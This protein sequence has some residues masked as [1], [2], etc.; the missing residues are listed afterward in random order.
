MVDVPENHVV[1]RE[2]D[3]GDSFYLMLEGHVEVLRTELNQEYVMAVL[4]PGE[5]FG[6]MALL[7]EA[8]R[9]ATIRS[10]DDCRLLQIKSEDFARLMRRYPP[11]LV[12]MNTLMGQRVSLLDVSSDEMTD[13]L[14]EHKLRFERR[15]E[16]DPRRSSI[17]LFRASTRAAG[18]Q[19]A[20]RRTQSGN[21]RPWLGRWAASCVPCCRIDP[22]MAGYLHEIGKIGLA[23]T[24]IEKERAGGELTRTTSEPEIDKVW[25]KTIRILHLSTST[26]TSAFAS[27]RFLGAQNYLEQPPRG[28]RSC[29]WHT[30]TS[31][32]WARTIGGCR[33]ARPWTR[34]GKGPAVATIRRSS[35]PSTRPWRSSSRSRPRTSSTSSST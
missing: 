32:W 14:K 20:P 13:Q 27:S 18:R 15:I 28:R 8:P 23:P 16:H 22:F 31:R 5:A 24:L 7:V 17:R 25:R 11:L 3:P 6:E 1:F 21:G 34:C 29:G 30:T 12:Q 35:W 19:S 4:D 2:G 10:T 33:G 9:S 26:S